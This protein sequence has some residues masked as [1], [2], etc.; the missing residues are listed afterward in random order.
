M[1]VGIYHHNQRYVKMVT[2]LPITLDFVRVAFSNVMLS[3]T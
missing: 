1:R 2:L 3:R